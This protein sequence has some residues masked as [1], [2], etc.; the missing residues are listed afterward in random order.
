MSRVG[1]SEQMD[2][3]ID[4]SNCELRKVAGRHCRG[5]RKK[6]TKKLLLLLLLIHWMSRE[7]GH[8]LTACRRKK[9]THRLSGCTASWLVGWMDG[10]MIGQRVGTLRLTDCSARLDDLQLGHVQVISVAYET[11]TNQTERLTEC[12]SEWVSDWLLARSVSRL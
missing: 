4:G 6:P 12:V 3:Q 8:Y 10:C 11:L 7:I 2:R 5:L 1:A 9:K